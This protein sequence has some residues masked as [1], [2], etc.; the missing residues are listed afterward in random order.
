MFADQDV[1]D[2]EG[3]CDEDIVLSFKITGSEQDFGDRRQGKAS[4]KLKA[5][6]R[7]LGTAKRNLHRMLINGIRGV[8]E[9]YFAE[10]DSF[11]IKNYENVLDNE[12]EVRDDSLYGTIVHNEEELGYLLMQKIRML[13]IGSSI[14]VFIWDMSAKVKIKHLVAD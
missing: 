5:Y 12:Y 13:D 3:F 7:Y 14:N 10:Y 11:E 6:S 9:E 2:G 4:Y 8:L 1:P